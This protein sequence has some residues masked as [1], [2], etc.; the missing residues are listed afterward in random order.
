MYSFLSRLD[1][2][3]SDL[4]MVAK[5]ALPSENHQVLSQALCQDQKVLSPRTS[6]ES[7]TKSK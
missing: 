6:P 5:L 3:K 2:N 1:D 7:S 4:S